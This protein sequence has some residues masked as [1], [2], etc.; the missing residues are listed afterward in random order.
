MGIFTAMKGV[1]TF[2]SHHLP[3]SCTWHDPHERHSVSTHQDVVILRRPF[4]GIVIFRLTRYTMVQ[5]IRRADKPFATSCWFSR[6]KRPAEYFRSLRTLLRVH[7]SFQHIRLTLHRVCPINASHAP[8]ARYI[9][10]RPISSHTTIT[11]EVPMLTLLK[12]SLCVGVVVIVAATCLGN[13]QGP[14]GA[15]NR[16]RTGRYEPVARTTIEEQRTQGECRIL[17]GRG[18]GIPGSGAAHAD[19][20]KRRR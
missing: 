1:S 11:A 2:E 17:A 10:C 12:K 13:R 5:W 7:P 6:S 8:I 4:I 14:G 16:E 20:A 19:V 15:S 3:L 18:K 9:Q